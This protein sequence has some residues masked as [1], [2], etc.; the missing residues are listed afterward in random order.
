LW[1]FGLFG[2]EACGLRF[3]I[4]DCYAGEK[5]LGVLGAIPFIFIYSHFKVCNVAFTFVQMEFICLERTFMCVMGLF[6]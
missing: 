6:S 3:A 1:L 2:E 4:A 5:C